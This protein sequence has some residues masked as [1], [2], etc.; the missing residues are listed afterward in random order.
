MQCFDLALNR[1]FEHHFEVEDYFNTNLYNDDILR[2]MDDILRRAMMQGL[3]YEGKKESARV[4]EFEREFLSHEV[5][6]KYMS[7]NNL[8][9]IQAKAFTP[10]VNDMAA[11]IKTSIKN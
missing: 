2:D 5:I 4:L 3:Q 9:P 7:D 6:A 1:A 8:R 10:I 11:Q